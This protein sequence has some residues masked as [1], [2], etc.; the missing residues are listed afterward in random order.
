MRVPELRRAYL[1]FPWPRL[2]EHPHSVALPTLN[3]KWND[4]YATIAC[5]LLYPER[6]PLLEIQAK[7]NA[8]QNDPFEKH[9]TLRRL[10]RNTRFPRPI[11]RALW[12]TGLYVSGGFRARTFGTFAINTVAGFRSR[13]LQFVTRMALTSPEPP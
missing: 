1:P 3:R 5:P 4:E 9:G 6:K 11:R 2:Y 13:M 8:L 12:A 10:V 7:L